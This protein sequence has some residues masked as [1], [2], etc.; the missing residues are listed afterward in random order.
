[1]LVQQLGE[2]VRALST[3]YP[4]LKMVFLSSQI[5][6]GY[7]STP[8][9]PEPYAYESGFAVKWLV[10]AQI[11]QMDGQGIDSQAGDLD[12]G[13]TTPWLAW[14]PYFWADGLIPRSD[15]LTWECNDLAA[16][17]THPSGAGRLKVSG[18]LLDFFLNS[19]FSQPWFTG[20]VDETLTV[21][22][23][24]GGEVFQKGQ[25]EQ[26]SWTSSGEP[27][28]SVR[29][30]LHKGNRFITIASAAADSG[31]FD[32][33]VPSW[34]PNASDYQIEV[35]PLTDLDAADFSDGFFTIQVPPVTADVTV[36]SPNGGETLEKG[37]IERISWSSSAA[38][39]ENVRIRLRNGTRAHTIAHITPNDGE[40][41]WNVPT[42]LPAI[43]GFTIEIAIAPDFQVLDTSDGSFSL[44]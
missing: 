34:L 32:W 28:G 4:N 23:P 30:R 35:A 19:P 39:D 10:E 12:Y 3:R 6:G 9:N 11:N 24:N 33:T 44:E 17:G 7:A 22:T 37:Q 13:A 20:S 8:L 16:D 25:T 40:F 2:I 18:L 42:W 14:G 31:Q 27:S 41:D 36:V 15:G 21:L 29:L 26:I 5:Y 38:N 1:V 43:S